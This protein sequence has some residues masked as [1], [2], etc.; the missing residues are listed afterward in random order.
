MLKELGRIESMKK[1]GEIE[2]SSAT[3][4]ADDLWL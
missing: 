4:I 2:K 1:G 3:Y